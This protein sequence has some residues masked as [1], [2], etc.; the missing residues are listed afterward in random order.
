MPSIRA[1]DKTLSAVCRNGRTRLSG[2]ILEMTKKT[3][4][5]ENTTNIIAKSPICLNDFTT[6]NFGRFLHKNI[7]FCEDGIRVY[8]LGG[9]NSNKSTVTIFN[10]EGIRQ[11]KEIWEK[12]AYKR[13]V[14]AYDKNGVNPVN[15]PNM[16]LNILT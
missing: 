11:L 5:V 13:T 4:F 6:D 14:I 15:V 1:L 8:K 16:V 3:R 12:A 9:K 10:R 7:T 2:T